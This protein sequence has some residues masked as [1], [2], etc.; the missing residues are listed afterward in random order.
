MSD[1]SVRVARPP[2]YLRVGELTRDVYV[3]DGFVHPD[4]DYDQVLLDVVTRARSSEILVAVDDSD[5]ALGAVT[6]CPPGTA[7]VQVA[8]DGE[9]EF[10]ML[11]VDTAARGRGIGEQ[12]VG[13]VLDRARANGSGA[14]RMSS[15]PEM[16][17]AHRLYARLG[18]TRTPDRDWSPVPDL[19]LFTFQYL[20]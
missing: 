12:L 4:S 18:F 2:E 10:R 20:L 7:Y 9:S 16:T 17:T 13:A 1:V 6:Y 5:T 11:V 14:V 3:A 8:D 19:K 15:D